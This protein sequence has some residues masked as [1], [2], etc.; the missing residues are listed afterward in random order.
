[1]TATTKTTT[2]GEATP[3]LTFGADLSPA[4]AAIEAAYRLF[5][6]AFP[7]A[8]DVT[9]VVKRDGRAWGHTT[10]AKVWAPAAQ[11][12][13]DRFEIMISGENLR[14]GAEAV[15]ATLLH[16]AAHARNL[17]AGVLDCDVNGRHN[18]AFKATAEAHGLT[19]EQVTWHGWTK[20]ELSDAG[21]KR[22][23]RLVKVIAKGLGQAAAAAAPVVDH[24]GKPAPAGD[25]DEEGTPTPAPAT[26]RKR[27]D[28]NLLKASCP[29]GYSIRLSRGL[30]DTA[31]P[32]CQ[33]C[34]QPFEVPAAD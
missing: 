29:C 21:R 22:W 25:G 2:A 16:E 18:L 11:S 17:A 15:A 33:E 26:P 3:V 13:A 12:T 23:A 4:V 24:L 19:V 32:L 27:G 9:I 28:R 7:D 8:P 1:M 34:D 20:T 30:L 31:R 10:V 14:R 6:K 5:Q